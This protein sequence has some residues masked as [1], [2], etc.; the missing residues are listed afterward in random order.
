MHL[1]KK[2]ATT[3]VVATLM[4]FIALMTPASQAQYA[5]PQEGGSIPLPAGVTPDLTYESISY[6]SFRPNPV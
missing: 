4:T 2:V 1:S 6:M 5:N 3:I